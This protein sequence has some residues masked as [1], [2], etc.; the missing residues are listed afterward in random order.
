MTQGTEERL[1]DAIRAY[2]QTVEP[3]P[4]AWAQVRE[5]L[6]SPRR[7]ARRWPMILVGAGAVA[8]IALG[9]VA[10]DMLR[11]GGHGPASAGSAPRE[12]VAWAAPPNTAVVVLSTRDGH[13]IRTLDAP[14]TS[15]ATVRV[16]TSPD[17]R[18]AYFDRPTQITGSCYIPEVFRVSVRG[19]TREAITHGELATPSPNGRS[20]AL[21]RST[22]GDT[23]GNTDV[24]VIRDLASGRER[25]YQAAAGRIARLSWSA[26]S[27]DVFYRTTAASPTPTQAS[28]IL[29]TRSPTNRP[30][31]RELPIRDQI[32]P[33]GYL[34]R[35][36][37]LMA[38]YYPPGGSAQIVGLDPTTLAIRTR[39]VQ[40]SSVGAG[41]QS[42]DSDT[43]GAHLVFVLA[44]GP[45]GN[46]DT[47]RWSVGK[48]T[49]TRISNGLLEVA[50]VP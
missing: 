4:G 24:V 17:G 43:T 41:L 47:F 15:M 11:S 44:H 39:L 14:D 50:W 3:S 16:A 31:Q 49:P 20:L 25:V 38:A 9:V 22:T 35:S 18:F 28:Y 37:Q 8:A 1:R 10:V 30:H 42:I 36:G 12:V 40:F 23:C 32:Y 29:D 19:G 46:I 34:G 2:A 5:R 13:I 48:T 33:E 21:V 7:R 45:D 6:S 27:R 26:D